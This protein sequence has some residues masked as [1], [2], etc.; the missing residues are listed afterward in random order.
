MDQ[1][2]RSARSLYKNNSIPFLFFLPYGLA[3]IPHP[4]VT[5][6]RN[7]KMI[8]DCFRS[9]PYCPTIFPFPYFYYFSLFFVLKYPTTTH[10]VRRHAA[11]VH[12]RLRPFFLFLTFTMATLSFIFLCV[13]CKTPAHSVLHPSFAATAT[14][15][16]LKIS[17]FT[18][19]YD[20]CI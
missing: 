3:S 6:G 7:S 14:V 18:S 17:Y 9:P 11:T 12:S 2:R 10:H 15:P 20:V 4:A 8:R 1:F 13:P 16:L 19:K 5:P